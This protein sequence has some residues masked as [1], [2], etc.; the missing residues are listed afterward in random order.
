MRKFAIFDGI[1]GVVSLS[2]AHCIGCLLLLVDNGN[3]DIH[4]VMVIVFL[5]FQCSLA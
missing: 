1:C 2:Y 5:L 3:S 4:M